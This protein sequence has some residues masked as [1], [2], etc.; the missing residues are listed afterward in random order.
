MNRVNQTRAVSTPLWP[1]PCQIC[2]ILYHSAGG[3]DDEPI[4]PFSGTVVRR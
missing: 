2:V 1:D 3:E 4:Y